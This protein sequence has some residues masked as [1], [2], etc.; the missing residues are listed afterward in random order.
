VQQ[1]A[2]LALRA[3]TQ[4]QAE[5]R[6]LPLAQLA[7]RQLER[8]RVLPAAGLQLAV[9]QLPQPVRRR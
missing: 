3:Q 7:L 9:R 5:A 2:P 1:A 8:G 6:R 4:R